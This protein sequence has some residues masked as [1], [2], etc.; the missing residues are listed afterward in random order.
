MLAMNKGVILKILSLFLLLL[1]LQGKSNAQWILQGGLLDEQVHRGIELTYNMDYAAADRTFDSVITENP[2]HPSGYFY[3]AMVNFWRAVTNT[4]NTGYDEAYRQQLDL[5]IQRCDNL[6]DL[7]DLDLAG[8]FIKV[9]HLECGLAFL[10]FD[11]TGKMPS[12]YSLAMQKR[13]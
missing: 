10:P 2:S 9:L 1:L 12:A 11:R 7:N 5:C 13:E 6:L 4:D 3:K 8:L